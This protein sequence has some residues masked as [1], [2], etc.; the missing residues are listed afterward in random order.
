MRAKSDAPT[1]AAKQVLCVFMGHAHGNSRAEPRR[2]AIAQHSPTC[3]AS[4]P[5]SARARTFG[6]RGGYGPPSSS[7]HFLTSFQAQPLVILHLVLSSL[8]QVGS[9]P[10]DSPPLVSPPLVSPPLA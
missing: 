4:S 8:A 2:R 7:T 5:T 3:V 9:P 10:L 6:R 1:E